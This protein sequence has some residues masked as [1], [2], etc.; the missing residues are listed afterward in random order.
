MNSNSS[1]LRK[2][3]TE[4]LMQEK[5]WPNASVAFSSWNRMTQ[6]LVRT[7]AV[8]AVSRSTKPR[9]WP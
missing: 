2:R 6:M 8:M 7:E 1:S 4:R 5:G 9:N 3:N